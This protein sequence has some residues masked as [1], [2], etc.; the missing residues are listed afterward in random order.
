[1][2]NIFVFA[3]L[4]SFSSCTQVADWFGTTEDSTSTTTNT[5]TGNYAA[6][7]E[8]R[9]QSITAENAYSDLFLDT[10]AVEQYIQKE[11]L[12][13]EEAKQFRGF[14]N[15]RNY[16][17]AWFA[18]DGMTEQGQTIWA[19]YNERNSDN[20]KEKSATSVSEHMDTI[21]QKDSIQISAGD[22]SFVQTELALTRLLM[23]QAKENR[24]GLINT[25][26][27]YFIVPAKKQDPM[28]MADSIL[29]SQ[30]TSQYSNNKAY[31]A[32]RSH[33][34]KYYEAAKSETPDTATSTPVRKGKS[35]ANI[36]SVK[37]KLTMLGYYTANDTSSVSNDSLKNAIKIYQASNGLKADGNLNDSTMKSL[38][39]PA[40]QRVEQILVN[41]NRLLWSRAI[42]DSNYIQVNIPSFM[43]YTFEGDQKVFEMPVIVGKQGTNTVMFNGELSQIVF[44]PYW[45]IPESIVKN[46]LLPAMKKDKS[47][48]RKKNMEIV[49]MGKDSI[50]TIRQ[51]PGKDNSLGTM[52]FLFPNSFDIYLHDT[53]DKGLFAKNNRA[54]SHGCI[55]VADAPKLAAYL[56]EGQN[57]WTEEKIKATTGTGKEETVSLQKKMPVMITYY[58]AWVDETGK[59]RFANDVYQHDQNTM[60]RMFTGKQ[61]MNIAATRTDSLQKSDSSKKLVRP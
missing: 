46:E 9:D 4:I 26:N 17:Y 52:K 36:P 40:K 34:A 10:A 31:M 43:L 50:P 14:Y 32:L 45:N 6:R 16:Q 18:S 29:N 38:N 59:L 12:S 27:F 1:M 19:L 13:G 2:K 24:N 42:T 20:K 48:L 33:L 44:N 57:G 37:R 22:S 25:N 23:K 47:Y 35:T 11:G 55:R 49:S 30:D 7:L 28:A 8:V 3:L 51:L 21:I 61:D 53:P 39:V 58:T 56:L 15:V 41:M 54:Q 60:A 5:S